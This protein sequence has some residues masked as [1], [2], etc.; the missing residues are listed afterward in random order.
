MSIAILYVIATI[1]LM[2]AALVKDTIVGDHS[3]AYRWNL[4]I[5]LLGGIQTAMTGVGFTLLI[6]TAL[7]TGA[8]L[9][10]TAE[11]FRTIRDSGGA[12]LVVGGSSLI[13]I[14]GSG[15]A[16][17]GIPLLALFGLSGAIA[18]LPFQGTEISV[19]AVILLLVSLY[20]LLKDSPR[21]AACEAQSNTSPVWKRK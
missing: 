3:F 13:G 1:Y 17:C 20:V 12:H 4:L 8:T 5:A 7:L 10:L 18:Y 21:I 14:V 6:I 16:S 9:V 15:C 19:I 2:N 11:R